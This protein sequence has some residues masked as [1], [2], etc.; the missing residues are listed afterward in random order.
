MRQK[1]D[2]TWVTLLNNIKTGNYRKPGE[3]FTI[4][5]YKKIRLYL[6]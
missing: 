5:I 4:K 6:L 3:Y 2:Q 1:V